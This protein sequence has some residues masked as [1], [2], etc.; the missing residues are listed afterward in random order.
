[1]KVVNNYD[2]FVVKWFCL[3]R[4]KNYEYIVWFVNG[5]IRGFCWFYFYFVNFI[6]EG[7]CGGFGEVNINDIIFI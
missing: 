1:M 7:I 5:V 4:V 2:Y 6:Y 3:I